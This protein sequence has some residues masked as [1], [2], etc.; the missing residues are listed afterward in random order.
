M[1]SSVSTDL[2]I[3]FSIG[4]IPKAE[5]DLINLTP[6]LNFSLKI[7]ISGTSV[8]MSVRL[9]WIYH[10]DRFMGYV[11]VNLTLF[12]RLQEHLEC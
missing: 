4:M 8:S 9:A 5:K 12:S 10:S 11:L 2:N 1:R 6:L 7:E 3:A